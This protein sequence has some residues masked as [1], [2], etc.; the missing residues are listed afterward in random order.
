MMNDN[1]NEEEPVEAA[2]GGMSYI[3]RLVHELEN[4]PNNVGVDGDNNA[5]SGMGEEDTASDDDD[6]W[7]YSEEEES[8]DDEFEY[9]SEEEDIELQRQSPDDIADF[10][11]FWYEDHPNPNV[12]DESKQLLLWRLGKDESFS[13]WTIQISSTTNNE[14]SMKKTYHVHK[15][16]L[17]IGPK[18]SGYFE[19]LLQSGQYSESSNSKSV[20]ELPEYAAVYFDAFLDYMYAQLSE[21]ERI[22]NRSNRRALQYLAKYFLV[23]KLTKDI[24]DYIEEDMRG[25]DNMEEYLAEFGGA[26]DEESRKM[27]ALAVRVCATNVIHIGLASSLLYSLT[28]AM[29]LHIISVV[30]VSKNLL[31]LSEDHKHHI[32]KLAVEYFKHHRTNLDVNY[33][34][35]LTSELYFPDDIVYAGEVAYDILSLIELMGWEV[36]IITVGIKSACDVVLSR[37]LRRNVDIDK[38]PRMT[39]DLPRTSVSYTLVDSITEASKKKFNTRTKRVTTFDNVSCKLMSLRFGRPLQTILEVSFSSIN[40]IDYIR[41]LISRQ[42]N[43]LGYMDKILIWNNNKYLHGSQ[44][45]VWDCRISDNTVLEVYNNEYNDF[46][47]EDEEGGGG[48]GEEDDDDEEDGGNEEEQA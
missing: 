40:T 5:S 47:N 48:E 14:E 10:T 32:C 41:Y 22:I 24:H 16:T 6:D 27:L 2:N 28:P 45:L 39:G 7:I 37:Y 44:Q 25:L 31:K 12:S 46:L 15:V 36:E 9:D 30:R 29:F 38:I 26:E 13:D 43:M 33:F 35:A 11:E 42:L 20:V 23:H 17:A 1:N 4:D 8:T 34:V 21:R 3:D 19:A 18:K